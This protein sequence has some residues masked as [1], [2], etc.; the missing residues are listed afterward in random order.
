MTQT[1][2]APETRQL[3]WQQ[4]N[5]EYLGVALRRLRLLLER[6]LLWLRRQWNDDPLHLQNLQGTLVS[7]ARADWLVSG[8]DDPD[9]EDRFYAE[10]SEAAR[11][12]SVINQVEKDLAAR[13]R[14]FEKA[15]TSSAL[16]VLTRLFTLTPFECEVLVLGAAPQVDGAFERLYAYVQD[17]V[18]R[19]YPTVHLALSLFRQVDDQGSAPDSFQPE[20]PLMRFR[21]LSL[22]PEAAQG[23]TPAARPLIVE[24]RIVDYL[25][26]VN[27][28]DEAAASLLR[29]L[30]GAPVVIPQQELIERLTSSLAT[31]EGKSPLRVVNLIGAPGMGQ[32]AMAQ[33]LCDR[34]GLGL[35]HLDPGRLPAPGL[36]RADLFR[37]LEREALL[38]PTAYYLDDGGGDQEDPAVADARQ[39]IVDR[40]AA[41]VIVGSRTRQ[42]S[43]GPVLAVTLNKPDAQGQQALWKQVLGDTDEAL[44]QGLAAI[45]QQFDLGPEAI[46]RA[47]EDAKIQANM[48]KRQTQAG[49]EVDDLWQAC[50]ELARQPLEDRAQRLEPCWG[51]S[52]IVL[53]RDTAE[54]LRELAA[55]VAH[56]ARVY[57]DWGFSSRLNR[58]RGINALFSGPSGTG[59]TMA[60]EVLAGHLGLD[61]YRID[62][63]GVVSK[64]IG[65][66][67]KNLRKLFDAAEASGAILFFDEADA[68]F[69]KRTEVKDSHDRYANIEIGYL[70]QRMEDYR[71]LAVL[72]TNR[73]S[74]LDRAFLRRLRFLI[75]FPFPDAAA[76]RRIWHKVFPPQTQLAELDYDALARLEIAGGNIRNIALNAAFLAAD[77]GTAVGMREIMHAARR[78]YA[79]IEKMATESEFG[80]HYRR[81][82]Q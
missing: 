41:L 56:R 34:L 72:A 55:Q 4:A 20:A 19:R 51:W 46:V 32:R 57:V 1:A 23:L 71:G 76:R 77:K 44:E 14:E 66:T 36:E 69:G 6:R 50:R 58:G 11:L 75:D 10:D 65:E 70:L 9:L 42:R 59:K 79:K 13:R 73:K 18:A 21:L 81:S 60:A 28:L 8:A 24:Q 54:Q 43:E 49:I 62:L 48:G 22:G 30:P 82:T 78:E 7:D 39:E 3:T 16:E 74:D 63:A 12:G 5:R 47:A 61:L 38:V 26:G 2:P 35:V 80:A 45:V 52:D 15:G 27:R 40:L 31:Q 37:V 68:L 64:Y 25:R 33:A 29:P 67:E 53:P 17:D